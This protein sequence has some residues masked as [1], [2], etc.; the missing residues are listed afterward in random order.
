M[1]LLSRLRGALR[2]LV[3]GEPYRLKRTGIPAITAEEVAEIRQ[4]SRATN[5]SS[6]GT[7]AQGRR[8]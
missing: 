5:S 1:D 7:P 4:S 2:L 3:K 8:C 6:S